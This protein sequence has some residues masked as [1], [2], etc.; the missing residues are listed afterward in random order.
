MN[1]TS[2]TCNLPVSWLDQIRKNLKPSTTMT[3][4]GTV[5]VS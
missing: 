2:A 3:I 1:G 5:L 4:I